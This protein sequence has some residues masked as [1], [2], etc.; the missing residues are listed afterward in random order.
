MGAVY[1][2]DDLATLTREIKD[3]ALT[4]VGEFYVWRE[5]LPI[6]SPFGGRNQY[7]EATATGGLVF[8]GTSTI[9]IV[10]SVNLVLGGSS[11]D[12]FNPAMVGII[13]F[14][15]DDDAPASFVSGSSFAKLDNIGPNAAGPLRGR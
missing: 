14:G 3:A 4:G 6:E 12:Y 1:G 5:T 2:Q 10:Y 15:G 11:T 13:H 7:V 9:S 8:G